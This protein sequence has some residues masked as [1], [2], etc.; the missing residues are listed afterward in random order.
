MEL[1]EIDLGTFEADV[2]FLENGS[3]DVW[4]SHE[5]SSGSHYTDVSADRI[6]ELLAGDIEC[7]AESYGVFT[8]GKGLTLS[9]AKEL[10]NF[11]IE[12]ESAGRNCKDTLKHLL[13][14]GFTKDELSTEFGFSPSDI[15]DAMEDMDDYED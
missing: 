10:L 4:L 9:R 8:T 3:Y 2:K 11:V 7:F 13:F 14:L 15:Q 5:G 1:K 6:G 12:H